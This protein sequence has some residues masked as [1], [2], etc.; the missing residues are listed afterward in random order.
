[1]LPG[2]HVRLGPDRHS[3]AMLTDPGGPV[4]PMPDDWRPV[5]VAVAILTDPG[6]PVLP[7]WS[8]TG[9]IAIHPLRSSPTPEGRC[10]LL[11]DIDP[12]ELARVAI[13]TDPGG[14]VLPSSEGWPSGGGPPLRSS[15][16]PEGRCCVLTIGEP[17]TDTP[18]LR[19]SPTPE[20]R[21]CMTGHTSSSCRAALRSSPTPEGRCCAL[22]GTAWLRAVTGCDPHRPRRAGAAARAA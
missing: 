4:L 14:P 21:C 20:G 17:E 19:S 7:E 9:V 5:A 13:L 16:T 8:N 22:L 3:V 10:C 15:P 6:G 11:L 2:A 1:M 18:W 12:A